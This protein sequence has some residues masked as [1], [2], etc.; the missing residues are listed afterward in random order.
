MPHKNMPKNNAHQLKRKFVFKQSSCST[1]L[2]TQKTC[3]KDELLRMLELSKEPHR[4]SQKITLA[5]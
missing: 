5:V 3:L 4:T 2:Q 1:M